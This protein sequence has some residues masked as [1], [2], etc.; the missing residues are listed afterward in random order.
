MAKI[1]GIY[2]R[3]LR[4]KNDN[5]RNLIAYE[6]HTRDSVA[7]IIYVCPKCDETSEFRFNYGKGRENIDM[8][9][10]DAKGGE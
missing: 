3:E 1:N 2:V 4:C 5:C 10:D 7:I 9:I 6:R 8:L